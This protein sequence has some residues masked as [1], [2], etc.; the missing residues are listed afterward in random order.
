LAR[1]FG[2]VFS[3]TAF[4]VVGQIEL[5]HVPRAHIKNRKSQ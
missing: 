2:E 3:Q 4:A 1:F 5:R